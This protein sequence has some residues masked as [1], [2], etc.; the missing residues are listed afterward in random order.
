MPQDSPACLGRPSLEAPRG[1]PTNTSNYGGLQRKATSN[2]D[3]VHHEQNCGNSGATTVGV[4]EAR[5]GGLHQP[6]TMAAAAVWGDEYRTTTDFWGVWRLDGQRPP[7][8]G[9]LHGT[10][11]G[12]P[13]WPQQVPWGKASRCGGDLSEYVGK[14]CVGG[15]G[16]V[17][18]GGDHALLMGEGR[19]E[20]QWRH[21][22]EAET[23]LGGPRDTA[24]K[25]DS[26]RLERI[27]QTRA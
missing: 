23:A 13:H 8:L 27:Q 26:R 22:E 9:G 20:I 16:G 3:G 17:G 10:D 2:G 19:E 5:R 7:T 4:R 21:A 24:S 11:V 25:L 18:Q 12:D 15:D 1:P 6:V 14:V